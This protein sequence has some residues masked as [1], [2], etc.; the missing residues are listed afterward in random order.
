MGGAWFRKSGRRHLLID[1]GALIA[2]IGTASATLWALQ[3]LFR[4]LFTGVVAR[5]PSRRSRRKGSVRLE[6]DAVD[7]GVQIVG[8]SLYGFL[9]ACTSFGLGALYLWDR[10]LRPRARAERLEIA[11]APLDTAIFKELAQIAPR[12]WNALRLY[13]CWQGPSLL[14]YQLLSPEGHADEVVIPE[15]VY[16]RVAELQKLFNREWMTFASLGY[17]LTRTDDGTWQQELEQN[18]IRDLRGV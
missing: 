7:Y 15:T 8:W 1:L 11:R 3:H 13:V 10:S 4:G 16:A 12:H 18:G 17:D 5:A 2:T 14:Y 9:L 6:D